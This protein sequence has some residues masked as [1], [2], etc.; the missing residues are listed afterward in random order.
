MFATFGRHRFA[1]QTLFDSCCWLAALLLAMWIHVDFATAS[2]DVGQVA[3]LGAVA[4][5][6]QILIGIWRG[7]YIHRWRYGT[8]EEVTNLCLTIALATGLI[9]VVAAVAGGLDAAAV[10]FIAGPVALCLMAAGRFL[11]REA[12]ERR[13]RPDRNSGEPVIMFGAGRGATHLISSMLSN[14]ASP[15]VPVA[16]L[17]DNPRHTNLRIKGVPVVGTRE[18]LA[19]TAAEVGASTMVIAIP[20]APGQLIRELVALADA[21]GVDVLVAPSVSEMLSDA[22]G[23][24]DIRRVTE[25]DLLGRREIETDVGA[26][27]GYLS[28]RRVLVT[29]AGG[30]IGSELCRQ[31]ARYV[32]AELTLLDHDESRLHDTR[33]E[34]HHDS[35]D[36]SISLVVCDV[37]DHDR[38]LEVFGDTRP[39]VVFHAAAL[40]HVPLLEEHPDE[41]LKTNVWGTYH[42]LDAAGEN[43]VDVFVNIST[44]KAAD[45]SSVLGHTKRV[46]E[47]LTAHAGLGRRGKYLSVRFGNVLGS[48][49]SVLPL[50]QFQI[51][52]GG[53]V[54]VTHPDVTRYFMT[55]DEACQLVVQAGALGKSQEVMVLDMGE[56]VRILDVAERLVSESGD[57]IEIEFSGLRPGEK[58]HEVLSGEGE[59]L[60]PSAHPLIQCVEVPPIAPEDFFATDAG[61]ID[62][63]ARIEAQVETLSASGSD[64]G[65]DDRVRSGDSA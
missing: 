64:S 27:S 53:P 9:T 62:L 44:D 43:D 52:H 19:R 10:A 50:F 25:A 5:A 33:L 51:E 57:S 37:R 28:G 24:T 41:G 42:L 16:L 6:S 4:V 8:F 60:K 39:E 3:I 22:V 38:V 18:D 31:V 58:L 17:D 59:D 29:G 49:G 46:A 61:V 2:F 20:S 45:P 7:L 21:A 12:L 11:F 32:P 30:S 13:S 47:R 23:I 65:R 40:K 26:V 14:P 56:P 55:V 36:A 54:T 35:P 63:T 1:L 15:Y 34:I 48:R